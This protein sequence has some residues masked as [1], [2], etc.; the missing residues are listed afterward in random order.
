MN[1]DMTLT[2]HP[3]IQTNITDALR[4]IEH[5]EQVRILYACESGSRAWG[6]PSQDSDYDV[7]FLYVRPAEYYFSI[8]VEHRRDVIERPISEMLDVSGWDLRKALLLLRKSNPPLMEW[9]RSPLVY[10]QRT[11]AVETMRT[12]A[13]D[14]Y[15]PTASLYHY[16]HMARGNYRDYLRG[17]VVWMK[18][19]F[20]VLRPLL[21]ILWIEDGRGIPPMA[22]DTLLE[23]MITD[24]P[25]RQAIDALLVR[26]KAGEELDRQPRIPV[27]SDFI[28]REVERPESTHFEPG[29]RLPENDALNDF[30]REA[31]RGAWNT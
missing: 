19:Y 4:D 29:Q 1:N 21:A 16:L 23:A 9:L 7:R 27:I 10:H 6:F 17:D 28:A 25:L 18:K 26:K 15:Q 30:F 3:A 11:D 20:Y 13:E 22:F 5:T 12:L 31:V 24:A 14:Y 8:D 2:I